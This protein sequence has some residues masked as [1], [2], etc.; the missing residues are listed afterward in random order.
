MAPS[1][2]ETVGLTLTVKNDIVTAV[3]VQ[4]MAGDETSSQFQQMCGMKI[5]M[6]VVGMNL[7]DLNTIKISGASLTPKG[8][9]A[10]I[11][12]IKADAKA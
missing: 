3:S 11:S 1:G 10:A 12:T 5:S 2:R 6:M 4:D 8:F 7:A 9:T